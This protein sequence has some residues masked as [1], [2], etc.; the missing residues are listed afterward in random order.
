M[1]TPAVYPR[2]NIYL[3][4]PELRTHIKIAAAHHGVTVSGYC[5]EA[6]RR[7]LAAEGILPTA[8]AGGE[9]P[10]GTAQGAAQA[11]D[12]LREHIGPIGVP[13]SELIAEGRRR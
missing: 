11:L 5:L 9:Q 1:A 3:D 13:V 7:R 12:R 10:Q 6:I 8:E 4:D 2:I